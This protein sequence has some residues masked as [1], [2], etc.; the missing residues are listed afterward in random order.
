MIEGLEVGELLGRGGGPLPAHPQHVCLRCVR[1]LP[2]HAQEL[3]APAPLTTLIP[4][5]IP[6][7]YGKVYKG[8]WNGAV[9][10]VKARSC[11]W[12]AALSEPA[13]C[14]LGDSASCRQ[15]RLPD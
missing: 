8:R 1:C 7:A 9:V 14:V 3:S 2:A 10:A 12:L 15:L 6:A 5:L 4:H 11:S 13:C